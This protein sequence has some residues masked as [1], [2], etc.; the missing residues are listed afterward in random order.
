MVVDTSALVA[1]LLDEPETEAFGRVLATTPG[2]ALSTANYVE[3]GFLARSRRR[4]SLAEV[5]AALE[6]WRIEV[7]PVSLVHARLAVEAFARYG[8]GNHPARLNYG[9]CFAYALAKERGEPL[10]FKGDDFPLTDI[11]P[12][13]R[14]P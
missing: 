6:H 3:F 7:V 12:A 11:T 4:Q 10:L 8:R 2:P 1:I 14:R 5:D 13:L 9:D